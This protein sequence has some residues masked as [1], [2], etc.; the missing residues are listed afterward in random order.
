MSLYPELSWSRPG[1]W[2]PR[3]VLLRLQITLGGQ[4]AARLNRR[5][6]WSKWEPRATPATPHGDFAEPIVLPQR[7]G[8]L[9]PGDNPA[10]IEIAYQQYE[11]LAECYRNAGLEI[12]AAPNLDQFIA[13]RQAGSSGWS[14]QSEAIRQIGTEATTAAEKACHIPTPGELNVSG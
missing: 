2:S 12:S 9:L 1:P 8:Y 11:V 3:R 5:S 14:P 6:N 10:N 7:A 4:V 13:A